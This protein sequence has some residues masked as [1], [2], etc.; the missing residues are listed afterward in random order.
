MIEFSGLELP[1]KCP[2]CGS[3]IR[4][5][6]RTHKFRML[7]VGYECDAVLS[8]SFAGGGPDRVVSVTAG[9]RKAMEQALHPNVPQ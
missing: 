6:R 1:E 5:E 8:T 3:V 7:T 4:E 9:C 2:T